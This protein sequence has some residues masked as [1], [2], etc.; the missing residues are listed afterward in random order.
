MIADTADPLQKT[1]LG[2]N[3]LG[4]RVTEAIKQ[5]IVTEVGK[6]GAADD[7]LLQRAEEGKELFGALGEK[8]E[9]DIA[10]GEA[11]SSKN[12]GE[13]VGLKVEIGKSKVCNVAMGGYPPEGDLAPQIVVTLL[14][15]A[16][17]TDVMLAVDYHV[18]PPI[19]VCP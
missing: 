14:T 12:I 3:S 13:T 7:L 10:W 15:S 19:D 17:V 1:L 2:D 9:E 6:K 8:C 11:K 18:S 4:L 5:G 16:D